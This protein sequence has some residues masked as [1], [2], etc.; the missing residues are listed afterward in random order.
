MNKSIICLM[1]PTACS[2]TNLAI[3][4]AQ[5][6]PFEIISVDSA[7]VYRGM[8]IGT[9]KPT[10]EELAL[11]PHRLINICDPAEAYSV[12]R[13][14][15]DAKREIKDIHQHGK[16]PLLV[17]G[18][19]LYF[20]LLQTGLTDLPG[21]DEAIRANINAEAESLGW[22]AM[23][24]KL[25]DIDPVSAAHI[26]PNDSQRIQRALELYYYTGQTMTERHASQIFKPLPYDIV[27]F[28]IAYKNRKTLHQR[29]AMRF[30]AML[31]QGLIE[32]VK[33][34]YAR[35]DLNENLPSIRTVGYRQV[36]HYLKG[37]YDLTTLRERA[38]IATRQFAKR[39]YIWLRPWKDAMWFY[40]E[41]DL[42]FEIA[43][44]EFLVSFLKK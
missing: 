32:E 4:L 44:T 26:H 8:D 30:D 16:I 13:F 17:G 11:A 28:I 7:M 10:A 27:N 39:Q 36:W 34:L 22:A 2:K 3:E 19:M 35:D 40:H 9:A 5:K 41:D 15:E 1:G 31:D 18:T 21:A 23:H 12:G 43:I 25:R 6:F 20:H 24:T 33:K 37:E 38:I 29:I 42:S 14:C